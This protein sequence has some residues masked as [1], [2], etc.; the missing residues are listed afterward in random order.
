MPR[1]RSSPGTIP[2]TG[3]HGPDPQDPSR[4]PAGHPAI[5]RFTVTHH[6]AAPPR[7]PTG[8]GN[9]SVAESADSGLGL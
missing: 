9:T 5:V 1:R 4:P 2:S 3:Q 8:T 6:S 7:T